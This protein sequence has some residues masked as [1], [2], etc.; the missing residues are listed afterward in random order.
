M[1]DADFGELGTNG[2][3]RKALVLEQS[4]LRLEWTASTLTSPPHSVAPEPAADLVSIP[5]HAAKGRVI[6]TGHR[7]YC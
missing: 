3:Q 1:D 5:V 7:S 2:L 6:D 4:T